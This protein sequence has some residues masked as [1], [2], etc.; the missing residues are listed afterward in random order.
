MIRRLAAFALAIV[1]AAQSAHAEPFD[2]TG[3]KLPI[4]LEFLVSPQSS[5]ID[6]KNPRE[7]EVLLIYVQG[8]ASS[9]AGEWPGAISKEIGSRAFQRMTMTMVASGDKLLQNV[10]FAGLEDA[11]V[12]AKRF[13]PTSTTGRAVAGL[14][15]K[16][17]G[18]K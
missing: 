5:K 1:L 11:K 10:G 15:V 9:L 16:V 4:A 14:V 6:L 18:A 3:Y 17:V 8:F 13:A 12:F 2:R 7:Q